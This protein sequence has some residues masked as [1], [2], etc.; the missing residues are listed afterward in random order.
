MKSLVLV[1]E[2]RK[3][4]C[5]SSYIAPNTRPLTKHEL[6]NLRRTNSSIQLPGDTSYR[7]RREILHIDV[8]IDYCQL[9]F[10]ITNGRQIE[11]FPN[12]TR[13]QI[14]PKPLIFTNGKIEEQKPQKPL[15][16]GLAYF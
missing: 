3:C 1:V 13:F 2:H 9:C 6:D 10:H 7:A 5:G 8:P 16:F 12:E 11:L 15:P 4:R 14:S